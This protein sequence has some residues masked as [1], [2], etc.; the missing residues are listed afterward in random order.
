MSKYTG[1]HLTWFLGRG[2]IPHYTWRDPDGEVW[3]DGGARGN[4]EGTYASGLPYNTPGIALPDRSTL[5]WWCRVSLPRQNALIILRHVDIG[6]RKPV[7]DITAQAAFIL[8]TKRANFP[9]F[10]PW[11]VDPVGLHLP[12][13]EQATMT[14]L[15]TGEVTPVP[16]TL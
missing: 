2:P 14:N 16:D 6:P 15:R 7:L 12:E 11:A 13:G 1:T 9:D 3:T 8:F 10:T 5:G 4:D